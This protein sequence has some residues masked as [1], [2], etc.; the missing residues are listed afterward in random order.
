MYLIVRIPRSAS[1]SFPHAIELARMAPSFTREGHGDDWSDVAMFT[2]LPQSLDLAVRLI[3][4]VVDIP[5]VWVSMHAKRVAG[6]TNFWSALIHYRESLDALDPRQYCAATA[7]RYT[8]VRGCPDHAW[9]SPCQFICPRCIGV[10][11]HRGAESVQAEVQALAVQTKVDW[12]HNLR[13]AQVLT[14]AIGLN[15][16][17]GGSAR[18]SAAGH[19]IADTTH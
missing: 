11:R 6:I 18:S 2:E 7:K 15:G 17:I 5:D 14:R 12:C 8:D 1:Q 10:E 4:A 16:L 3:D 9:L 19:C 13:C